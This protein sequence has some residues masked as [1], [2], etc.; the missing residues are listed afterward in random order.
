MIHD[1]RYDTKFNDIRYIL[2]FNNYGSNTLKLLN[3]LG[4]RILNNDNN[5]PSGADS[6]SGGANKSPIRWF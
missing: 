2:R 6:V 3:V 1:K 5:H 4:E